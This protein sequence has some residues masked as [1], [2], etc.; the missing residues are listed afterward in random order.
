VQI[1][2][3]GH[4]L[5]RHD[6][7]TFNQIISV[8]SLYALFTYTFLLIN[9]F[10]KFLKLITKLLGYQKRKLRKEACVLLKTVFLYTNTTT[11]CLS[12]LLFTQASGGVGCSALLVRFEC[13]RILLQPEFQYP[14]CVEIAEQTHTGGQ[15]KN[16]NHRHAKG[17]RICIL[18]QLISSLNCHSRTLIFVHLSSPP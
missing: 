14:R 7:F 8:F 15:E 4:I 9:F 16:R 11:C 18:P 13:A 1:S 5:Y 2:T 10:T 3:I 6:F 12:L 17:I